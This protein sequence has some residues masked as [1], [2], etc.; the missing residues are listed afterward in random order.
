MDESKR[1]EAED[2]LVQRD[3]ARTARDFARADALRDAIAALGFRVIDAPTGASLE[4]SSVEAHGAAP[5]RAADVPSALDEPATFDVSLQWVDEG[6]P[7]DIL[8]AI[9][10]FRRHAGGRRLQFVVVRET[11][12]VEPDGVSWPEDVEVIRLA[13]RPGW[14][15]ARNAGLRRARAEAIVV[16]DGSVEPTGDALAPLLEALRDPTVGIAGPFGIVT[17]DLRSF[18]ASEGPEVDAIEAYCMAFRR[19]LVGE[20]GG[21]DPRFRF[22]R[23][24]DIEFSFRVRE[25]GLRTVVVAAPV[26]R[27]EHRMWTSTPIAERDAASK[28]NYYRFLERFRGR[29]DLTVAGRRRTPRG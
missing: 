6:W 19:G 1:R 18:E 17:A 24:A 23:S 25:R 8:R 2:L 11:D 14:A 27:H 29:T 4:E 28:R 5:V 21:F 16:L 20:T 3:A 10:A 9:H 12:D 13:D 7:D 26:E 22:Y 15:V